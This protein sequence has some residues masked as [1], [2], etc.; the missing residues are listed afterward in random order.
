MILSLSTVAYAASVTNARWGL[1]K[2][3]N[4]R[5]V[6]SVS[7][8][9]TYNIRLNGQVLKVLV[10]ADLDKSS[11]G[12]WEVR[13]DLAKTMTMKKEGALS[14]LE[15]NLSKTITSDNYKTFVLRNAG[16]GQAPYRIVVDVNNGTV[17]NVA[18]TV[19]SNKPTKPAN[20]GSTW[21]P[22]QTSVSSGSW[23]DR[24]KKD[25]TSQPKQSVSERIKQNI[26]QAKNSK[27][28]TVVNTVPDK[29]IPVVPTSDSSV[30]MTSGNSSTAD[31]V[32]RA[33]AN[34]QSSLKKLLTAKQAARR[35]AAAEA[36]NKKKKNG[37]VK[38]AVLQE[39]V[40]KQ[41][42]DGVVVI[43]GTGKYKTSGG[44]VGKVITLDAGHGGTDPGAIGTGG[45]MEKNL[46]LPVT[47][48]VQALL[49]KAGAS[50]HMTRTTDVDVHGP[51]ATD[52]QE[53]QARVNVAEKFSS[54]LF[55]SIH[56]NSSVNKGITGVSSYYYPKTVHDSRIARCIQNKLVAV[57]KMNDL[58]IREAGFY[59]IKRNSMPATLLELGFISNRK[60]ESI[61]ASSAY[62]EKAAQA[63]F[64]GIK[65]YFEG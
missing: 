65:K 51:Y 53:L 40:N 27:S 2:D 58:G 57:C 35:E 6:I 16:A 60:E 44:I 26:Q 50:V 12:T 29:T 62:Q 32:S 22:S 56:I 19:V 45:N 61:M 9:V 25:G 43:K 63:I 4:L 14:V 42:V 38:P 36:A 41:T 13:G 54:D 37:K 39:T 34:T 23:T 21:A 47:K 52:K 11:A 49:T 8:P 30:K 64:E 55:V 18:K 10:N 7:A 17:T 20:N 48:K 15:V 33:K 1:D 31:A 46:T 59:V 24:F 5:F 3:N 28:D